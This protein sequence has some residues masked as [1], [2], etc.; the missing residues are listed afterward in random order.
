MD[1]MKSTSIEIGETN[2]VQE[3]IKS[4]KL[5]KSEK[6][7]DGTNVTRNDSV[8]SDDSDESDSGLYTNNNETNKGPNTKYD[9]DDLYTASDGNTKQ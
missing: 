7:A 5:D 9:N 4:D 6:S 3:G 1:R 8:W 2:I